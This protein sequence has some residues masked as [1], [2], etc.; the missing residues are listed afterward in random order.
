MKTAL[1]LVAALFAVFSLSAN[2]PVKVGHRGSVWGVENTRAAFA[3]GV[4]RYP[5]IECDVRLTA[6]SV[7]VIS[8]DENTERLGGN[9]VIAQTPLADLKA[10]RYTQTRGDIVYAGEISTLAEYL[11]QCKDAGVGCV[12]EMKWTPGVNNDD[13]SMIPALMAEIEKAGMTENVI[14]LTS[15]KKC[16]EAIG[17]DYP[18]VKRQFLG[19]AKWKDSMDW[20]KQQ[21]IDVDLIWTAVQPEDV[22]M[23]HDMGLKVNVWTVDSPETAANLAEMGV[24]F[25]T[26][27]KL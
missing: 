14:M 20:I 25:I 24:D 13:Q 6:D 26:T 21:N 8:H 22:K 27:N 23:L 5:L 10:E 15:M 2:E 7:F 4:K 18:H 3:N 19:G 12:V 16:L 9:K 1:S 17:R 11:Q